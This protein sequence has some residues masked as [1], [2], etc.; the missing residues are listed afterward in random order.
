MHCYRGHRAQRSSRGLAGTLLV[1][2]SH[3][4]TPSPCSIPLDLFCL[5]IGLHSV[6]VALRDCSVGSVRD[7]ENARSSVPS[8]A[9]CH[10]FWLLRF[11][12][13][14]S[15]SWLV[16]AIAKARSLSCL[17]LDSESAHEVLDEKANANNKTQLGNFLPFLLYFL[18][19]IVLIYF[20]NFTPK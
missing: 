13:A 6:L 17:R 3:P 20:L 1:F 9:I 18:I 11:R 8:S 10:L 4:P 7:E 5:W 2:A 16:L 12:V 19:F 15:L 14:N